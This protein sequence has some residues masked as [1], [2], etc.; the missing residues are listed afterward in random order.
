MRYAV[1]LAGGGEAALAAY[2]LTDAEHRVEKELAQ[3]WPGA[4][5]SV[6]EVRRGAAEERI[7]EEFV[8]GYRLRGRLSVEAG[9]PEEAR[10]QA[11]REGRARLAGSRY[12][13]I[14][15]ESARVEAA[16]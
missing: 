7:V 8:V 12:A 4:H 9:S 16:P 3:L 13:G 10:R 6:A 1:H 15:W 14:R 11:F 2:G 5:V